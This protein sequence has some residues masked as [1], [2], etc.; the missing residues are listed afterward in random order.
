MLQTTRFATCLSLLAGSLAIATAAQADIPITNG[1]VGGQAAFFIDGKKSPVLFDTAIQTLRM[2][3]PNGTSTTSR[4]LPNASRFTDVNGNKLP[5]AGDTG[6]LEGGLSGVAF[7]RTGQPVFFQNVP[8]ALDF[9]LNSFTPNT[10]SLGSLISPKQE[11]TAPPLFLSLVDVTLSSASSAN[12]ESRTGGLFIGP[13]SANL[14]GDFIGLPSDLQFRAPATDVTLLPVS[15]GR[16]IKFDF[17]GNDVEGNGTF[18]SGDSFG[19]DDGDDDDGFSFG[20]DDGDDDDGDDDDDGNEVLQLINAQKL[21]FAG[22]VTKFQIQSVG[23]SGSSEF[24]VTGSGSL[25]IELTGPFDIKKA[26]LNLNETEGQLSYRIK[27]EGP[28][29][30]SF[31]GSDYLTYSGTSRRDTD[32]KFEQGGKVFEGKSSGDVKFAVGSEEGLNSF[33]N[34]TVPIVG[35]TSSG[36]TFVPGSISTSVSTSTTFVFSTTVF[37]NTTI[38]NFPGYYNLL[39]ETSRDNDDDDGDDDDNYG[40]NV[41]YYIYTPRRQATEVVIE[42]QGDRILLVDRSETRGRK[43]KKRGQVIGAYQVVGLPS[44]VFPGLTGL[45]QLPPEQ[46]ESTTDTDS[47]SGTGTPSGTGTSNT[48]GSTPPSP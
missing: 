7:S 20:D 12:F 9:T 19:D 27:G 3:T 28:G 38:T 34:F 1:Q 42:R 41:V 6:R 16:R 40:N 39:I 46:V 44:R 48:G 30:V 14:T 15:L 8:T 22:D 45:R 31:R 4:F 13:F 36:A 29:F 33:E 32:F 10:L 37:T 43:L 25:A 21:R 2:V 35:V 26:D 18:G 11:G 5:D 23:T 17:E 24:K 47:T